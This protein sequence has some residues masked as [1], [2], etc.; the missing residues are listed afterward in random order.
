MSV[1]RAS[2]MRS[3]GRFSPE[4][5]AVWKF[6]HK[7]VQ[8][9]FELS[10]DYVP[11]PDF[12]A[13]SLDREVEKRVLGSTPTGQSP[14]DMTSAPAQMSP[15]VASL[16]QTSLLTR[17]QE[18]YLFRK[19]NYLKYKASGLRERLRS[20]RPQR[21][22]LQRI[23]RLCQEIAVL[24]NQIVCANLRLVVFIA[25][26][27]VRSGEDFFSLVSDGNV[28]LM[29]AVE[30][31]DYSLGNRFSTYAASAV[32]R[33][34]VRTIP[35]CLR[36]RSRFLNGCEGLLMETPD[37]RTDPHEQEA[38]KARRKAV[39]NSILQR[40]SDRER[41]IIVF[42][43]GLRRGQGPQTHQWI[44]NVMGVTKQRIRQIE[45]RA[46]RKMRQAMSE[47]L[48]QSVTVADIS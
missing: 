26:R 9:I 16:Y 3:P 40:L 6:L 15:Y 23:E 5:E 2:S 48:L 10:L 27:H 33:N 14:M 36:E 22:L 31:F 13:W 45:M 37:I 38:A 12:E 35:R 4:A 20:S 24:R 42:R 29:R 46:I 32:I 7:R 34:F 41:E 1:Q 47:K 25:K 17:E 28:S 11:N 19:M 21:S 44:G 39:L 30:R 43:F 18:I 8:R